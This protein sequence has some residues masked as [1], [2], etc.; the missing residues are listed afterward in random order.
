MSDEVHRACAPRSATWRCCSWSRWGWSST[1]RSRTGLGA[2]W[3]SVTTP[4]AQHAFWLTITI[5]LIAV[6]LNTVFGV[7]T[8]LV[9]ARHE[10]RGKRSSTR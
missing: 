6:P 1:A 8:A 2:A 3:E 5:T 7:A 4:E 9:L 10:F